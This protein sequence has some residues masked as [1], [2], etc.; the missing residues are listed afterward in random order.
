[1]TGDTPEGFSTP[2]NFTSC[3]LNSRNRREVCRS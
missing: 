3:I 1:M 2:N